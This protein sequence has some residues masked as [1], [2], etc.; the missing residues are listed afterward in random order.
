MK[1]TVRGFTLIELLVTMSILGILF[2]IGIAEYNKFNR[3]Q[4]L[5]QAAQE[6]KTNLRLAQDKALA[7]EKD[8]SVCQVGLVCGDSDDLV[9]DGWYV[10]FSSGSYQIYGSCDGSQFPSSPKTVNLISE[11]TIT[12]SPLLPHTIR[13]KPI[14]QGVE[15]ETTITL[16]G[17]DQEEE[18]TVTTTGDIR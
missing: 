4:I 16:S 10:S 5:V 11:I 2:G 1:K 14:G 6:L 12:T 18:V 13:F 8:C 9:L 7:G 3:R 15:E 17:F